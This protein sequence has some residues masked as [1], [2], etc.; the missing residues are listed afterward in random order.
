MDA[1]P[2]K[3]KGQ[4]HHVWCLWPFPSRHQKGFVTASDSIHHSRKIILSQQKK[5]FV[6]ASESIRHAGVSRLLVACPVP[7]L[8]SGVPVRSF[9][10]YI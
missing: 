9:F 6:T 3:Q 2:K 8:F 7:C 10:L 4:K 5:H 1:L